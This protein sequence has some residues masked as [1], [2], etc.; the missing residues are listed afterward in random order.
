VAHLAGRANAAEADLGAAI[1]AAAAQHYGFGEA[2]GRIVRGEVLADAGRHGAA[3]A[4]H[5]ATVSILVGNP[6]RMLRAAA[7]GA[8]AKSLVGT[9]AV[10]LAGLALGAADREHPV[11]EGTWV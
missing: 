1:D 2:I 3:I 4:D 6:D 10:A 8:L 9:G 11:S 5:S 7:L